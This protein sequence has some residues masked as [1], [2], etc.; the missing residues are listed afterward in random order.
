M[1]EPEKLASIRFTDGF[2]LQ[3]LWDRRGSYLWIGPESGP[4]LIKCS[5]KRASVKRFCKKALRALNSKR[6]LGG[7]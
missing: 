4:G 5:R 2:V 7:E 6:P 3:V 1:K